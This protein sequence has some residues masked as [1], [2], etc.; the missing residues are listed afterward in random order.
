MASVVPVIVVIVA[1]DG[2]ESACQ[3]I[4]SNQPG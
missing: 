1:M 4:A 3:S 2:A